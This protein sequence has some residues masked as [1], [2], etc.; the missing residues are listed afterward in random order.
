M[1][2]KSEIRSIIDGSKLLIKLAIFGAVLAFAL[3]LAGLL[4]GV[5]SDTFVQSDIFAIGIIPYLAALLFALGAIFYGL[6]R[7]T[8]AQEEEE[9]ML[10]MKRKDNV[11]ILN[12]EEDV[13]FTAGRTFE[14]YKK[15][16]PYV[17]SILGVLLTGIM[18]FYFYREWYTVRPASLTENAAMDKKVVHATPVQTVVISVIFMLISIFAGAFF[19][20]R[21]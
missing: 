7:R 16:A 20:G 3:A 18:L 11:G 2:S 5:G 10:L 4:V 12:V 21:H 14:N 6:F 1:S 19:T 9:K 15:Y 13:R 8:A 17:L